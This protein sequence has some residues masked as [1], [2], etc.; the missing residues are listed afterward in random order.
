MSESI[1]F[2]L[3]AILGAVIFLAGQSWGRWLERRGY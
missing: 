2:F 3:A 1:Q